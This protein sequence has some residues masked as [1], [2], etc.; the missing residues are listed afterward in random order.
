MVVILKAKDCRSDIIIR[1]DE[2]TIKHD[3][4]PEVEIY[5]GPEAFMHYE[6]GYLNGEYKPFEFRFEANDNMEA[7][8]KHYHDCNDNDYGFLLG[9]RMALRGELE[10]WGLYK[11]QVH[12]NYL[13][14]S[15]G[16]RTAKNFQRVQIKNNFGRFYL[17]ESE[18]RE[19][20]RLKHN[21]NSILI[22]SEEKESIDT[23]KK[24]EVGVAEDGCTTVKRTYLLGK[25]IRTVEEFKEVAAPFKKG[26]SDFYWKL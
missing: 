6:K 21:Y 22:E 1:G 23:L 11:V 19:I 18:C 15:F 25:H 26:G 14:L 5:P 17:E 12:A 9:Y 10:G 7:I 24:L 2:L 8:A 16:N 4:C 20:I 13:E 3:L